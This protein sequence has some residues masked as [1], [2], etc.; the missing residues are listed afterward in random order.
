MNEFIYTETCG[1]AEWNM[2]LRKTRLS[3]RTRLNMSKADGSHVCI[4]Q[5]HH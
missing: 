1:A 3:L 2:L 5:G 4:P